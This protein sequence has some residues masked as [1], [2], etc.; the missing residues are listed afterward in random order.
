MGTEEWSLSGPLSGRVKV[1]LTGV[2]TTS[3]LSWHRKIISQ[4]TASFA[5]RSQVIQRLTPSV[6]FKSKRRT[7]WMFYNWAGFTRPNRTAPSDFCERCRHCHRQ[8]LY[9]MCH[10]SAYRLSYSNPLFAMRSWR[11]GNITSEKPAG[12]NE[13]R[14]WPCTNRTGIRHKGRCR[15]RLPDNQTNSDSNPDDLRTR[16]SP[17]E[18][19][20]D[21]WA[22][23]PDFIK[24][25]HEFR[26]RGNVQ[27]IHSREVLT[28]SLWERA[29]EKKRERKKKVSS[30]SLFR[31]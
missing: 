18:L 26:A 20:S 2:F 6:S 8:L 4:N 15:G 29:K 5:H 23:Q 12:K 28:Q 14:D 16:V 31:W 24:R 3:A 19:R 1:K 10:V 13:E 27:L 25:K 21:V 30:S 17:Q 11:N 7:A 22:L 9:C